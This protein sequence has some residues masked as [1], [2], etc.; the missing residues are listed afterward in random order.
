M[1]L[2]VCIFVFVAGLW[3]LMSAFDMLGF[4]SISADIKSGGLLAVICVGVG[5]VCEVVKAE[6]ENPDDK[7]E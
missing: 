5:L 3:L 1:F 7:Q 6:K 2:C 4:M